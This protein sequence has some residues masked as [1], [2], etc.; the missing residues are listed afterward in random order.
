MLPVSLI[1]RPENIALHDAQ[2]KGMDDLTVEV[3]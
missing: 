2:T 3:V 1:E